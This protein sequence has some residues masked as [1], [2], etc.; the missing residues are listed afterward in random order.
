MVDG[1]YVVFEMKYEVIADNGH[2]RLEPAEPE[3][4]RQIGAQ[5]GA[6]QRKS[7]AHRHRESA[8]RKPYGQKQKSYKIH[9]IELVL[10][11]QKY[12]KKLKSQMIFR[13][14]L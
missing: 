1:R 12:E 9:C 13:P 14:F 2:Q 8:H 7:L 3:S 6:F 5:A 4:H 10:K 11:L